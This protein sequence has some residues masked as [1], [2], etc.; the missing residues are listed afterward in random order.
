MDPFCWNVHV[1][2]AETHVRI[3]GILCNKVVAMSFTGE[4]ATKTT[5]VVRNPLMIKTGERGE[6][7]QLAPKNGEQPKNDPPIFPLQQ[8]LRIQNTPNAPKS[9]KPATTPNCPSSHYTRK[10]YAALKKKMDE[11]QAQNDNL[12]IEKVHQQT[13]IRQL[14]RTASTIEESK[15]VQSEKGM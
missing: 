14:E 8:N 5:I 10:D 7:S 1:T 6:N 13:R 2:S 4:N 9:L 12:K 11:L 15:K 3:N